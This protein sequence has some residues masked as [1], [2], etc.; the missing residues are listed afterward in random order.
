[1]SIKQFN[2][3]YHRTEDRVLFRFNTVESQEYRF[4]LT[5]RIT[6]FILAA[7]NHLWSKQLE[8]SHSKQ[9]AQAIAQFQQ[10]AAKQTLQVEQAAVS[11]AYEGGQLFP[12]GADPIL[13]TEVKCQT[14]QEGETD[15]LSI[16]LVLPGNGNVN[17]KLVGSTLQ[18]MC[19]LLDSL[20]LTA[21]WGDYTP[22]MP[23]VEPA[24]SGD[25][26]DQLKHQLH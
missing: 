8:G 2:G 26:T 12:L 5:R 16:D 25:A 9:A 24:Q 11:A 15:Y 23:S 21:Q 14:I 10:E 1:M 4:W 20:R 22:I 3:T 7:S 13:I 6:L 17:L 19:G 18:A